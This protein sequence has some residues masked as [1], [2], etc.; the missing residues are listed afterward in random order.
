MSTDPARAR[1][2]RVWLAIAALL[3]FA[4]I[5]VLV[6]LL[7]AS[8]NE[9]V[10]RSGSNHAEQ[11]AHADRFA[12]AAGGEQDPN[13][14]PAELVLAMRGRV[15][16]TERHPVAD[17]EVEL[18]YRPA[19]VEAKSTIVRSDANGEFV[20]PHLRAGYYRVEA[21][22]DDAVSATVEVQLSARSTPVMLIVVPAATINVRVVSATDDAP[23]A[24]ALVRVTPGNSELGPVEVMREARTD[25]SGIARIRGVLPVSNHGVYA[26]A[27][28]Y[29][30]T[31]INVLAGGNPNRQDWSTVIRLR[32]GGVVTGRVIDK[33]G[34]PISGATLRWYTGEAAKDAD[35]APGL[36]SS[37]Q[38]IVRM[39]TVRSGADGRFRFSA[40]VGPG[41]IEAAHPSHTVGFARGVVVAGS[42]LSLDVVVDSGAKLAGVVLDSAGNAVPGA[43][44]IA[45]KR[46]MSH[47]QMFM[48]VYRFRATTD[49]AGEFAFT[50][51]DRDELSLA[52][53]SAEGSSELVDVDLRTTPEQTG[54][55]LE[56]T[57]TGKITGVVVDD[58]GQPSSYAQ[59][60]FFVSSRTV[61]P[62]TGMTV[63]TYLPALF[64]NPRAQGVVTA[65]E[66]GRFVITGL[67]D[68]EYQLTARRVDA[69][70][71]APIFGEARVAKV[72]P[73]QD[74]TLTLPAL[75]SI[76]GRVVADDGGALVGVTVAAAGWQQEMSYPPGHV[77]AADGRFKLTQVPAGRYGLKI[78]GTAVVDW[79]SAQPFEVVGGRETDVGSIR[80]TRGIAAREGKVVDPSGAPVTGAQVIVQ[81]GI[82]RTVEDVTDEKGVFTVPPVP[83]ATVV[84][85][86]AYT[87]DVTSEWQTLAPDADD[88][89]ITLAAGA[90]GTIAGVLVENG[91]PA[92]NRTLMLIL[93]TATPVVDPNTQKSRGNAIT[94]SGGNFKF[95]DVPLGQYRLWVRRAGNDGPEWTAHGD[96]IVVQPG[97][98]VFI[99]VQLAHAP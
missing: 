26:G 47:Q 31:S 41:V 6:F 48:D 91:Q 20:I 17:A 33:Q 29:A 85:L 95:A 52:A 69:L 74:V 34:R 65:G 18:V 25:A 9:S 32:R 10:A 23:I 68:G 59:V 51:L 27:N 79:A 88:V 37:Q 45:T 80:I 1:R 35:Q 94:Q 50:G 11:A 53:W 84:R 99:V 71:V 5:A 21:R 44:V 38:G 46:G 96:P 86:R 93:D 39:G 55:V 54:I 8:P 89:K 64:A 30:G 43:E 73:G 67:V 36:F 42:E 4:V 90:S 12:R 56:L 22:H 97:K 3:V 98:E 81:M 40:D 28:G 24:N 7:R 13:V 76:S 49:R 77:V 75:G 16:D 14:D 63:D 78:R 62:P 58:G 15:V 57:R 60:S 2:G 82:G 83:L 72:R 66:D 19:S 61:T 92:E 87:R 70:S